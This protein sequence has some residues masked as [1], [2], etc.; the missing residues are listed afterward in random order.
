MLWH[1]Q[2]RRTCSGWLLGLLP[3][4]LS[5]RP[6]RAPKPAAPEP[7]P[8]APPASPLAALDAVLAS[9]RLLLLPCGVIAAACCGFGQFRSI[10]E[11]ADALLIWVGLG[12]LGLP[13]R[14]GAVPGLAAVAVTLLALNVLLVNVVKRVANGLVFLCKRWGGRPWLSVC[15]T[16]LC[17]SFV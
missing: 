9:P 17:W 11:P 1:L 16:H 15:S 5:A 4:A 2:A 3:P 14:L 10:A 12:R 13:P 7:P 6:P 8:P